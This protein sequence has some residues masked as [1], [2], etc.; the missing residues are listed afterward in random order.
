[1]Y[2]S[3]D[4]ARFKTDIN[5][6]QYAA[7][8]GY[9]IDDKKSTQS[10]IAMRKDSDKIIVSRK[11]ANW[12]YF[13]VTDDRDNGSIIDFIQHRTDQDLK[14][15]GVELNTWLGGGFKTVNPKSYVSNVKEQVFDPERIKK[16]FHYCKSIKTHSY[17]EGRGLGRTVIDSSRFAGRIFTDRYK[18]VLFP[19]F[20]KA[21]ICGIE[22]KSEGKGFFAKGSEKTLWRSNVKKTDTT[23]IIG[24]AVIDALSHYVLRGHDDGFYVV[25]G[26]G[27]SPEQ[28]MFL[29][30][31]IN[32]LS[33]L[34]EI[35]I[36]TDND[37]GGD[38]LTTRLIEI[39]SNSNF[40]DAPLRHSPDIR[41]EDWNDVLITNQ[42][43]GE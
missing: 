35:L 17:L 16:I 18:N 20:K 4:Y 13:S 33:N 30:D 3:L 23:L 29:I 39:I 38:K 28:G 10:S 8:I 21:Q 22:Y 7:H 19:H 11:G 2:Q 14:T 41:G 36:I 6:T 34:E 1:M 12:V 9:E 25:T 26:G 37:K 43:K 15:I 42:P 31:L 24:E 32:S 40:K 27:M 5:L